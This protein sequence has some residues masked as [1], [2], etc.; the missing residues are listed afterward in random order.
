MHK[1]CISLEAYLGERYCITIPPCRD[2]NLGECR[3]PKK[4]LGEQRSP[5]TTPLILTVILIN[6]LYIV[7]TSYCYRKCSILSF[8]FLFHFP[9]KIRVSYSAMDTSTNDVKL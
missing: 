7:Q 2:V 6:C 4:Y 1:L 8:F 9:T 5:S 3:S